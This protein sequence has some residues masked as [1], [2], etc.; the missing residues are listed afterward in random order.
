MKPDKEN[1]PGLTESLVAM[2]RKAGASQAEVTIGKATQFDVEIRNGRIENLQ[3]AGSRGLSLRVFVDQ[4]VATASSSDLSKETLSRLVSNAVERARL[5]GADSFAGLPDAAKVTVDA[6]TLG[7]YD[8]SLPTLAPEKKIAFAREMERIGLADKRITKSTGSS[9][10]TVIQEVFLANSNGFSG[11]Y[12]KTTSYCYLGLEAGASDNPMQDGW[13]DQALRFDALQSPELVAKTAVNRVTRLVG[14][15]KIESQNVP[16]ILEPSMTS[17]LLGF[18]AACIDGEAINQKQSFLVDK[19]GSKVGSDLVTIHD[20]G[21]MPGAMGTSPFDAEG[22][23]CRKTSVM[24]AG[25]LKSYLLDTYNARKL[26]SK[27][28]GNAGGPTNLY[29]AAGKTSPAEIIKSVDKG[30]L[31][32]GTMGQGTVPT[33]GD[34][35]RGAFG[36]WIEKGEIAYPVA[37]VTISGNL[38]EVLKNVVMVGSDLEFR[39]GITG[40]TLKIAEMTIGGK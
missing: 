14:A 5:S 31:L 10:G 19:L 9:V 32:T 15:K 28:T 36:M 34:I 22:V 11:S 33:T 4:K 16:V 29:L 17:A 30:F 27:S 3:E 24:E 6:A 1:L 13:F 23:P 12:R 26:K 40:P 25:V 37:E 18:F 7:L 21:L 2:A 35:S 39:R 20:D 8:P 38:G